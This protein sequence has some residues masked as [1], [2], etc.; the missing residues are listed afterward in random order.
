MS[1]DHDDYLA[2][3]AEIADKLSEAFEDV[4]LDGVT[5]EVVARRHTGRTF[6][7]GFHKPDPL[8]RSIMPKIARDGQGYPQGPQ[9]N[10]R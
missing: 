5:G 4:H 8:G 7:S 9:L 1:R 6:L 10:P 3:A 2:R